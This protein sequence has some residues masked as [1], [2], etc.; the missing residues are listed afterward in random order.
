MNCHTA[1]RMF[2]SPMVPSMPPSSKRRRE[3]AWVWNAVPRQSG[4]YERT[5][6]LLLIVLKLDFFSPFTLSLISSASLTYLTHSSINEDRPRFCHL[7][8]YWCTCPV[9][10]R[11]SVS[12]L[13]PVGLLS[14]HCVVPSAYVVQCEPTILSW[15]GGT[16]E[17]RVSLP[18]PAN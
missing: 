5:V 12:R 18:F 10:Y 16:G 7:F 15:T 1:I 4:D 3:G 17:C 14:P 6:R 8:C 2:P 13:L 9:Y 11:H